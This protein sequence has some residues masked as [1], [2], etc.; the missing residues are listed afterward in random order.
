MRTIRA[1]WTLSWLLAVAA[2]ANTTS[3]QGTVPASGDPDPRQAPEL[4]V[5]LVIDQLG[6]DLLE[7]Y[8]DVF[9]GGLAR[10]MSRGRW[11]VDGAH[12]HGV[13]ETSPGHATIATG[14]HP[15]HH[16]M[17]SNIW[18][19]QDERG[20]WSATENVIDP[21][22]RML[23]GEMYLG[24][25][26]AALMRS[27]LGDWIV[28]GDDEARVVSVSGKDR[29]AILLSGQGT[30]TVYWFAPELGRFASSTYYGTED[31]EWIT[32]FN[33]GLVE[34]MARDTTWESRIPPELVT[35]TRPDTASFEGDGV[36]TSFPHRFGEASDSLPPELPYWW[37]G[38]PYLDREVLALA[39]TALAALELGGRGS[40]DLLSISLSA[41]DRVGHPYGPGSREQLDNLLRLDRELGEFL[42]HLDEELGDRYLLAFTSDHGVSEAPEALEARGE[43]ARRLTVD[44]GQA[45]NEQAAGVLQE[46]ANDPE[47]LARG[48]AEEARAAAWIAEA[49]PSDTLPGVAGDSIAVLMAHS[50]YPGRAAGLLGRLGVEVVLTP[51]TLIWAWVRGTTHGSPYLYDRRVPVIFLGPGVAPGRIPGRAATASIA[52][53]LAREAG[54]RFPD[55]LDGVPLS[56]R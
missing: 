42:D 13:T 44:D 9:T 18:Y 11:F 34:R 21:A 2:C 30:H 14:T 12:E 25:S 49:W 41:T 56:L 46:H 38:T 45:F 53:T 33:A 6:A 27:A 39:R 19:T 23:G 3:T 26:P 28:D 50:L 32:A 43:S 15:S 48:L 24:S 17:V 40:T 8:E 16:G 7:R 4:L 52:P 29:A 31:P 35:R 10:L 22:V 54:I 20:T 55:D 47:A 36:H 1:R 5:L 51:H 37:S